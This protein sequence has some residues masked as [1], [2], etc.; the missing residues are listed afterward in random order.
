MGKVVGNDRKRFL[1]S[2][3]N[4][5]SCAWKLQSNPLSGRQ[6]DPIEL[7]EVDHKK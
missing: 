1:C 4:D 5:I 3:K 7:Q 6:K 2:E